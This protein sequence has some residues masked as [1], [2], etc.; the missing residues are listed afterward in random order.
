MS[1]GYSPSASARTL[2]LPFFSRCCSPCNRSS[3]QHFSI[4]KKNAQINRLKGLSQVCTFCT[5]PGSPLLCEAFDLTGTPCFLT[6]YQRQC[7]VG[8]CAIEQKRTRSVWVRA[9]GGLNTAV[10]QCCCFRCCKSPCEDDEVAGL[11]RLFKN[12]YSQMLFFTQKHMREA[13]EG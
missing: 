2:A 11:S 6:I 9:C 12:N 5:C 3:P 13:P 7:R 4:A 10:V 1:K 8:D